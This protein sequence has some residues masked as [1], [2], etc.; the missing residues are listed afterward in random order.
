MDLIERILQRAQQEG[1][2]DDTEH[3]ARRRIAVYNEACGPTLAWLRERKVPIIELDA[4]GTPSRTWQ[5]LL[6]VGRLMRSAVA[7]PD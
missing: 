5:Q 4:S 3:A 6:V 1:R 2:A 7:L